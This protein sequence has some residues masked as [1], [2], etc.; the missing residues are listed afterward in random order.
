MFEL[1]PELLGYVRKLLPLMEIYAAR[2]PAAPVRDAA[3]QEFQAYT[4]EVL[5]ANRADLMEL[6]SSMEGLQQRLRV[7]DDQSVALQREVSRAA[8]QQRAILIAAIVAA[9]CSL[10]ALVTGIIALSRH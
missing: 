6:R 9:V 8:D 2:R 4:A 7:I 10:G 5:R 3:T 1:L